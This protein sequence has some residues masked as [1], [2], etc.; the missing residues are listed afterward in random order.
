MRY[1]VIGGLGFTGNYLVKK[2]VDEG[3]EVVVL[4]HSENPKASRNV[5]ILTIDIT[6]EKMLR[7]V[8]LFSDDIVIH[9]AARQ[10]HSR[11]PRFNR[12]SYFNK[13]NYTG[14]K[15]ILNW[16][17]SH[18]CH[19]LIYFSS[20]M[21]YGFPKFLP[22]TTE[23]QKSPIGPYGKSKLKSEQLCAEFTKVG[24]RIT[25]FR[26]R[27]IIGPGRYGV[28]IKLFKL[29]K[30]GLPVPTIGSGYNHY[31]MVSVFDCVKAIEC[32]LE[33]NIPNAT[34]NLGSANPPIVNDLLMALINQAKSRSVLLPLPARLVKGVL[35]IFDFIGIPLM[36]PEQYLIADIEYRVD[37][38]NVM[39]DLNWQPEYSDIDMMSQS[40]EEFKQSSLPD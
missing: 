35:G 20:D 18:S 34:Y 13:V 39:E 16:M 2:L 22:V 1:I 12:E 15:N 11:L 28:L 3:Q 33:K 7:E 36:Y 19:S 21:V 6:D 25:I 23:H 40:F 30:V 4:D 37:I 10:Y 26:P 29:I 24:F 5:K 27:M 31:Q 8:P 38:S 14:T 9:L 32:A 17:K